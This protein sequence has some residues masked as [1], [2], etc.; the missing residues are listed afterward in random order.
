M[1]RNFDKKISESYWKLN[2][3]DRPFK[4]I[5]KKLKALDLLYNFNF[6]L[7][8][9]YLKD[10]DFDK[11]KLFKLNLVDRPFKWIDKKETGAVELVCNFHFSIHQ[12]FLLRFF[13]SSSIHPFNAY[14]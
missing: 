8:I 10:I 1:Y 6:Q 2:L 14:K 3:V 9:V 7:F 11:K 5:D 13:S 12:K 4:L